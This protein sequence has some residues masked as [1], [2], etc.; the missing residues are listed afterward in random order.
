MAFTAENTEIKMDFPSVEE[1]VLNALLKLPDVQAALEC[2]DEE[3]G[4]A[5]LRKCLR[6]RSL[7]SA[8]LP[9][10]KRF[11]RVFEGRVLIATWG[12][13][14]SGKT[15]LCRLLREVLGGQWINQDDIA[16]QNPEMRARD[17]F[18]E[19]VCAALHKKK[20]TRDRFL[21]I[22]KTNIL[23]QHRLDI[24]KELIKRKWFEKGHRSL[25]VEYVHKEDP[26][27]HGP[28]DSTVGRRYST[29]H[30]NYCM[31]RIE[32]RGEAHHTLK[33]SANNL[34]KVISKTAQSCERP[35]PDE[36]NLWGKSMTLNLTLG[37]VEACI[38][39]LKELY[40]TDA[41]EKPAESYR[42]MLE[43]AWIG[44]Q[45]AEEAWRD[46]EHENAVEEEQELPTCV[47]CKSRTDLVCDE[48]SNALYCRKCWKSWEKEN[49]REQARQDEYK[50]KDVE[51]KLVPRPLY[52]KISLPDISRR[53]SA[54]PTNLIPIEDPHVTLLYIG[55]KDD[56]FAADRLGLSVESFTALRDAL[57]D[58][59]GQ[60]MKVKMTKIVIE[61]T[62]AAVAVVEF[63]DPIPCAQKFPHVTLALAEDVRGSYSNT[64]LEKVKDE[65]YDPEQ[66]A[67][68]CMPDG[69]KL[70]EG[71]ISLQSTSS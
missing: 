32:K 7:L 6:K 51:R 14:G 61:T 41:I 1:K 2:E 60:T 34:V 44:L 63:V 28:K 17:A 69:G 47:S 52:W 20:T 38:E 59:E 57:Q 12:L 43:I 58:L 8:K 11:K 30:I 37:P 70:Y 55:A 31:R 19:E 56:E 45:R 64:L 23:R 18:M 53:I 50:N 36:Q 25:L 48:E 24:L 29:N 21:F 27:G 4:L 33:A 9:S 46:A 35:S 66:V 10:P 5:M 71:A 65:T 22:D 16:H 26:I 15:T 54:L 67:V 42:S 62:K 3:D 39:V 40:A 13:Q 68:V 49:Q